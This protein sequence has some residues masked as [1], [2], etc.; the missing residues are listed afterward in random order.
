VS[1]DQTNSALTGQLLNQL[2][3][4]S[5]ITNTAIC[6]VYDPKESINNWLA[7]FDLNA[8]HLGLDDQQ[9]LIHIG[10]YLPME[11]SNWIAR[12]TAVT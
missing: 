6:S 4:E 5:R 9:N 10:R 7:Q 2:L 3:T 11:I 12:S 1:T 8:Q